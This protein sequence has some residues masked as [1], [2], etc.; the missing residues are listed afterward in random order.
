MAE[1]VL[2]H[3]ETPTEV[4]WVVGNFVAA[5]E[6]LCGEHLQPCGCVHITNDK[7]S[8]TCEECIEIVEKAIEEV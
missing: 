8:V 4:H 1:K 7:V 2:T 3:M 5:N 6:T